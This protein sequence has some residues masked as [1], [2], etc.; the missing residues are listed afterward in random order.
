MLETFK[1]ER[2]IRKALRAIARQRVVLVL[3]PGNVLVVERSPLNE[4]WFDVAVRTSHIRGWVDVVHDSIPSATV[5]FEGGNLVFPQG[6]TPK[7][8]Y[9]LTEGGWAVIHR[10]HAWLIATFVVALLSLLAGIASVAL[11]LMT[12]NPSIEQTSSGL[13]PPSAAHVKR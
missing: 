13:R 9:R 5:Q 4:E 8:I 10:S 3:Q 2:A 6:M 7:S 12:A 11:S 1:R